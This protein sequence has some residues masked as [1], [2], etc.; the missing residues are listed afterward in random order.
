MTGDA[1][2]ETVRPAELEHALAAL[3][4]GDP[5]AGLFGPHSALWRVDREAALF[6]GSGRALLLQLA[7]PW[8]AAAIAAHSDALADPFGR[9]HRTFGTVY[10]MVFGTRA[11]ALGMARRLHRVHAGIAG[12]MPYGLGKFAAGSDY[13]ANEVAALRWVWA[14]LVDTALLAHDLA[15]P[16]L[17]ERERSR[18]YEDSLRF[19]ALF[20]LARDALP[21]DRVAF[22]AYMADMVGGDALAVGPDARRIGIGLVA[23]PKPWL[24]VP[25]WFRDLTAHTLPPRLREAYGLPCGPVERRR[26]D[27]AIRWI[28]RLYPL[29][30]RRL[31]HAGP[32]QEAMARLAGRGPDVPTRALNRVWIGRARLGG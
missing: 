5:D 28:R 27:R 15:L 14:T 24:P 3:A 8:V 12:R 22:A 20:G 32:Y 10:V 17:T 29:L 2:G 31:R 16:P 11:Q 6:L 4:G 13:R 30:P 9:F 23:A 7:H 19:G 25:R 18:Y 21:P 1:A 26:V